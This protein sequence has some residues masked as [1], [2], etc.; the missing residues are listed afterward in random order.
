MEIYR[1]LRTKYEN[2]PWKKPIK[3]QV[4]ST[5]IS[6]PNHGLWEDRAGW[7]RDGR[8]LLLLHTVGGWLRNPAP[9]EGWFIHVY[10][11]IYRVSTVQSDAGFLPST[12]SIKS[13]NKPKFCAN[14]QLSCLNL[15]WLA[16]WI[17]IFN[18]HLCQTLLLA[19]LL[20]RLP[21]WA[22]E[23]QLECPVEHQTWLK[24]GFWKSGF[25][26]LPTQPKNAINYP[27]GNGLYHL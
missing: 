18:D 23:T 5:W 9:V 12:V 26:E 4:P 8:S 3:F 7:L 24:M 15:P 21:A 22:W 20:F 2:N 14:L 25:K 19:F 27:F 16:C 1:N 6:S 13:I 17:A 10:P 11:I